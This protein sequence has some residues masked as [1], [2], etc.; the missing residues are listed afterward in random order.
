MA[1]E[2]S[3]TMI[4]ALYLLIVQGTF[5]AFDTLWY[6]EWVSK[7]PANPEA[8][9]ELRLHPF[10]SFIYGIIF[11]T[12]AWLKW[13]GWLTIILILLLIAEIIITLWD[14]IEEDSFRKL[15]KGERVSHAIMGIIYGGFLAFLIPELLDWI[16]EDTAFTTINYGVVSWILT[17]MAIGVTISAIRDAIVGFR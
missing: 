11:V 15:E 12:I 14:F 1:V 13:L 8:K 2:V 4:I 5:G 6:H 10:R 16:R 3:G 9:M 7:L 17:L